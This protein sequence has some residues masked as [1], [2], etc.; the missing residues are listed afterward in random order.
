[1]TTNQTDLHL[2]KISGSKH[3]DAGNVEAHIYRNG[4]HTNILNSLVAEIK[5][6]K[7]RWVVLFLF[8]FYSGA[9]AAQWIQYSIINNIIVK[10]Y[11]INDKWVDWTSMIYMIVYI[12]LIFPG[13]WFLDKM[14][15]RITALVGI[16]GTC[17]GS[18]IK[19]FSVQPDLFYVTFIGQTIVALAQVCIL[20]LPARIAAVWFGPHQV[21]SACSVGVFGNQLGI[22]VGFVLPPILVGN[23][24]DLEIIGSDLL[25]MFYCFAGFTTILMVLMIFF[26][27]DKPPTPPNPKRSIIPAAGTESEASFKRSLKNLAINRNYIL[28]LISYGMN[29]GV[30]YAISTL[31]NPVVL[32]YY[33]GHEVDTGRIGLTIV[34]AGM[35]G[36]VVSGVVLDQMRKF[37]ETTLAVYAFSMVGMWVFTFTLETG[38]IAVVYVTA[39]LLGFFMTGYLPVGFEFAA[40]LTYPE[41][42]GTSSGLLNAAAQVFGIGFTSLYSELFYSYG[43]IPADVFMSIML[44]LGTLITGFIKPDLRRQNAN[45]EN[46]APEFTVSAESVQVQ[47][48]DVIIIPTEKLKD[49]ST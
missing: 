23:S 37:K 21:S 47:S 27:R 34:L 4:L 1:M 18:W 33:P 31:L 26:F 24:D 30:F 12:P 7:R 32:K 45:R 36:S 40:E 28:L 19:V 16:V 20:S 11:G 43:D 5:L 6:Y 8:V 25:F 2:K 42:E 22:A 46:A 29:V 13:S 9:N 44:V 15:L 49:I 14:G 35:I 3:S 38:N 17:I 10:Y 48:S 41:P 39:G